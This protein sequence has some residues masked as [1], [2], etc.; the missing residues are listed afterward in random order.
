MTLCVLYANDAHCIL[1]DDS[2]CI[3]SDD[4]FC[5]LPDDSFLDVNANSLQA[6][7]AAYA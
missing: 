2:V 7:C 1:P 4:S 5:I 3:L 6:V